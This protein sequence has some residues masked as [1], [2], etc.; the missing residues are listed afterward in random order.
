MAAP[1]S[2]KKTRI[3][4][5]CEFSPRTDPPVGLS[6][7]PC[8]DGSILWVSP[9]RMS[10]LGGTTR[11][12]ALWGCNQQKPLPSQFRKPE[13]PDARSWRPRGS[14]RSSRS[15]S[16]AMASPHLLC[17]P[18]PGRELVLRLRVHPV[19][20]A[21]TSRSLTNYICQGPG[22][23]RGRRGRGFGGHYLAHSMPQ[24]FPSAEAR[25]AE[26][27]T[28]P[29]HC[30]SQTLVPL[31]IKPEFLTTSFGVSACLSCPPH[32]CPHAQTLRPQAPCQSPPLGHLLQP[33]PPPGG[34]PA[35][36]SQLRAPGS[37]PQRGPLPSRPASPTSL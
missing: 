6:P 25:Q 32:L 3:P 29:C 30:L 35:W 24:S 21:L 15:A 22:S 28:H 14:T 19:Q 10:F 7:S 12:R 36:A 2:V 31:E 23:T 18:P 37:P 9:L 8:L 26:T 27:H 20:G 13:A 1:P 17:P 16:S 33:L 11:S 5:I 4:H 34:L